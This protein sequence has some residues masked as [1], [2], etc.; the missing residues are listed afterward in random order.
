M[1]TKG[2]PWTSTTDSAGMASII[3]S[4]RTWA[5]A[6]H[7]KPDGDAA[8]T[9]LALVR[10]INRTGASAQ[11]WLVGPQPHWIDEIIGSTPARKIRPGEPF[12]LAAG[13]PEPEGIAVVDTGSW[14][15]LADLKGFLQPR[16]DR[17]ICIDHHL[18]GDADV[19]AVRLI[20][21]S[22]ASATQVL[23]PVCRE[24]LAVPSTA[25]LPIDVAEALYLGLAT[26][27]GWFRHQSVS[28]AVMRLAADLLEAGVDHCRLY[29]VIEQQERPSRLRLLARSLASLDVDET[30]RTAVMVIRRKDFIDSGADR[31]DST[32]FV[33]MPLTLMGVM[34]S[35]VI[36]EEAPGDD[37]S[38][39]CKISFRSKAGPGEIDVNLV[40][41][42]LGGGG[43][44]RASGAK[45]S[46]NAEHAKRAVLAAVKG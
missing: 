17:T 29:R 23:A 10:A 38:P 34:V 28:P 19:A 1:T 12:S 3:R 26:D 27:T 42:E 25:A 9:V 22:A 36:T 16:A 14:S 5:V 35:V 44:A 40:A 24:L 7:A 2:A 32:G 43:H 8:G 46:M 18:R 4:R 15:Q 30:T 41:S 21:T 33:E 39:C 31:N 13:E 37:G 6:A 11:A 20:D 45:V